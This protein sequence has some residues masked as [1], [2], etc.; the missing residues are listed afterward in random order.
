VAPDLTPVATEIGGA[1]NAAR[2]AARRALWAL[3]HHLE[4]VFQAHETL[5]PGVLFS[6]REVR[7]L[8]G[9][10]AQRVAADLANLKIAEDS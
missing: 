2:G 9:Q 5:N 7:V 1:G 8:V 6:A 3:A 10:H 4:D